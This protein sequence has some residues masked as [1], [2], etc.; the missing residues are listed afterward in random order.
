ML[1]T[2]QD[3]THSA[4]DR[5][6]N[7]VDKS[8]RDITFIEGDMVYLKVPTPLKTLKIG[9]CQKLSSR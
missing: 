3:S 8:C 6:R 4:Q 1:Q 2:T 7:Y 5:A 9:K